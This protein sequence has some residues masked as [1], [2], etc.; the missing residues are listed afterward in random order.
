MEMF[1]VGEVRRR[2]WILWSFYETLILLRFQLI[3]YLE[4]SEVERPVTIRTNTLKTRRRDLA[5]VNNPLRLSSLSWIT[6]VLSS[7]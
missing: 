6:Q 5:Q 2:R 4:A 1:R 3:E 7:I